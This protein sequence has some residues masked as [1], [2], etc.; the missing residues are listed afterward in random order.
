M[1]FEPDAALTTSFSFSFSF[2]PLPLGLLVILLASRCSSSCLSFCSASI[3]LRALGPTCLLCNRGST[4]WSSDSASD[5]A[6]SKLLRK[7]FWAL[8]VRSARGYAVLRGCGY[9]G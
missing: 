2:P 5:I 3:L 9:P 7:R 6:L 1:Y 8:A 4:D